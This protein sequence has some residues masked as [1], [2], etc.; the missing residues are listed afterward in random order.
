[1]A[2]SPGRRQAV[3]PEPPEPPT[4]VTFTAWSLVPR[5]ASEVWTVPADAN[6][7]VC[8]ET[9]ISAPHTDWHRCRHCTAVWCERCME[10]MYNAAMQHEDGDVELSCPQCRRSIAGMQHDG[11]VKRVTERI[12]CSE[13]VANRIIGYENVT[14]E[15][16]H[17]CACEEDGSPYF[18]MPS[19]AVARI[20]SRDAIC[21]VV[22]QVQGKRA[23]EQLRRNL[24]S[25]RYDAAWELVVVGYLSVLKR[26]AA[27]STILPFLELMRQDLSRLVDATPAPATGRGGRDRRAELCRLLAIV[28]GHI[29]EEKPT[30][31]RVTGAAASAFSAAGP[32]S[33][34]ERSPRR[35][36]ARPAAAANGGD[37]PPGGSSTSAS[38]EDRPT[39]RSGRHR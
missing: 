32:S 9:A 22:E 4:P 2:A 15:L 24:R 13:T 28:D 25:E 27:L 29:G 11:R 18:M 37:A 21:D 10:Q 39:R 20:M 31:S 23:L 19:G 26:E 33:T 6:C 8:F 14:T 38:G 30:A 35:K 34:A 7:I 12:R 1:M 16:V 3:P 5:D 36:R 17:L